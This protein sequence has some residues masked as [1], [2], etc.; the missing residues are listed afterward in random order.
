MGDPERYRKPEEIHKWQESD[1]IGIYRRYLLKNE[2]A[3]E[4]ELNEQDDQAEAE[5]AEAVHFAETSP[6][7]PAEEL[8]K[9]IYVEE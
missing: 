2:L 9:D 5:V 4:V 6:E 3:N 8:Y 1:P 7:P